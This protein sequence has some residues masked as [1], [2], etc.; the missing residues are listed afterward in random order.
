VCGRPQ[1]N[2][3]C[4]VSLRRSR[5]LPSAFNGQRGSCVLQAGVR[6][7]GFARSASPPAGLVLREAKELRVCH[8]LA[9]WPSVMTSMWSS[10][11]SKGAAT[12]A[13]A[14]VDGAAG[15]WP[16]HACASSNAACRVP[17]RW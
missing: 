14:V 15:R 2:R 11:S 6:G 9:T 7:T 5:V 13:Q 1:E 10:F 12:A 4:K 8:F 17:A 3:F 16:G